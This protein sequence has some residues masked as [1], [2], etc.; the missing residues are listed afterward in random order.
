MFAG[1]GDTADL[2]KAANAGLVVEPENPEALAEAILYLYN[3]PKKR[4][5]MGENGRRFVLEH[6]PREKLLKELEQVL[7]QVVSN[8]A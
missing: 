3:N 7:L 5:D 6:Y 4:R 8:Q 2:L 1:A